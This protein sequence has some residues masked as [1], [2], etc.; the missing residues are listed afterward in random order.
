[1]LPPEWHLFASRPSR[2][3]R[4]ERV[5]VGRW[6]QTLRTEL[7]L[8]LARAIFSQTVSPTY[9]KA[10][11]R[12]ILLLAALI[13]AVSTALACSYAVVVW[14]PS[15]DDD[16]PYY[17]IWSDGKSRWID[18]AGRRVRYEPQTRSSPDRLFLFKQDE[19]YGYLRNGKE[20]IAPRFL[21]AREFQE[22]RAPVVIDGPCRYLRRLT[23]SPTAKCDTE[24]AIVARSDSSPRCGELAPM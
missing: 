8:L 7:S 2:D 16:P 15:S 14:E 23:A 22:S 18:R 24:V 4:G 1:M 6:Q 21:D 19:L 5:P 17:P 13:A 9:N 10:V 12:G 20:A 11:P 3:R